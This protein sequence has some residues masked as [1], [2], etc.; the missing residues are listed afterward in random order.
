MPITVDID[1]MRAKRKMPVGEFAERVCITP[2]NLAV[3]KNGR[4]NVVRFTG[5]IAAVARSKWRVRSP[6][7]GFQGFNSRRSKCSSGR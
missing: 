4:A 3:L 5:M 1:V 2:A 6:A 7:G